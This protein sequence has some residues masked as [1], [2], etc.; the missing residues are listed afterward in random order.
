MPASLGDEGGVG[1]VIVCDH[2]DCH[3]E[4]NEDPRWAGTRLLVRKD[5]RRLLGGSYVS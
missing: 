4:V 3:M 2:P 1:L 5:P